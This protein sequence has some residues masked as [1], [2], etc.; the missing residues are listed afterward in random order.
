MYKITERQNSSGTYYEKQ[1]YSTKNELISTEY[2]KIRVYTS[3]TDNGKTL[4]MFYDSNMNPIDDAIN[5]INFGGMQGQSQNYILQATSAL[6]FLYAYLEIFHIDLS[7][8]ED[9][10]A[11]AYIDFLRGVSREGL[12]YT[13]DFK[14]RRTNE[15]ISSYLKVARK[16]VSYLGYDNHAFLTKSENL[17][18]I[19]M[20]ESEGA[21]TVRL[22]NVKVKTPKRTDYVPS[23]VNIEEYKNILETIK[24]TTTPLRDRVICRLLFEHGLRIGEVLGLTLEDI[25]MKETKDFQVQY[26]IEL[27]NRVSDTN[28]QNVKTIMNVTS[29]DDYNDPGY[30]RK[31]VGYQ[32]IVISEDLAMELLEYINTFHESDNYKY[33]ERR[34]KYA[35]ADSVPYGNPSITKNYYVFLNTLGRPLSENLWDKNL[36]EIFKK[37]GLA[38]DVGVRE[39]NL[40][41]RLRHGYA[42][43]LTNELHLSDFDVK[44][45]MRHKNLSTTAIYHNPTPE[46]TEKLQEKLIE[47]WNIYL[48]KDGEN[49]GC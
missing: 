11:R 21:K 28:E 25:K 24:G 6:R 22:Y 5:F 37:A 10:E 18:T 47:K 16:Y 45:L 2:I 41:H 20:P 29:I 13:T 30:I 12:L 8:M 3:K 34:E 39:K 17:K 46:D 23:Y 49:D 36:R 27:R 14:T 33:M 1:D 15:T 38:V 31:D 32:V 26:R 48:L 40:N 35:R 19:M 44:T 9:K 4:T 7:Q 42:M 43:Y